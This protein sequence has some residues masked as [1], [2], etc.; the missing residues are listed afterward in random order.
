ME[1]MPEPLQEMKS[2]VQQL[3]VSRGWHYYMDLCW[4]ARVL[5]PT[6]GMRVLDAGAG[7]GIVQW[8]LAQRGA[9]VLS[10][11][12]NRR[13]HPGRPFEQ[14]CAHSK[15]GDD[16]SYAG[17]GFRSFLPPRRFWSPS[18]WTAKAEQLRQ[19]LYPRAPRFEGSVVFWDH[20]LRD[21]SRVESDSMDAI[22][23]ISALEHNDLD[24]LRT[25]V[26]ELE[27]VLKPGGKMAI[28][29]GGARDEDWFHEPSKGW[30]YTEKSLCEIFGLDAYETNFARYDDI[31]NDLVHCDELADDLPALYFESG[32]NGM[33]WGR[34]D[35]QYHSV[36]ICKT[37]AGA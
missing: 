4:V 7:N 22:V 15:W 37:K 16:P 21:L 20:D 23:S 34:W 17:L 30:C 3:D 12:L 31:L 5:D 18:E 14:W 13:V 6:P 9:H 8:W 25:I 2:L 32:E 27:R 33:P 11:D 28:T 10:V 36:G 35:P 24:N 29:V 19:K 1:E 26:L